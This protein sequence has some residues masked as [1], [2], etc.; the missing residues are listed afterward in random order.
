MITRI[1]RLQLAVRSHERS[2]ELFSRLFDAAVVR[3]D[4]LPKLGARRRVLR[5]GESEL[6]LLEPDGLGIVAQ[7]ISRYPTPIFAVGLATNDV[8]AARASLD[9][10]AI[11]HEVLGD[12]LW[13]TGEWLG[14]PGMRVV[15][16]QDERRES[17]GLLSRVY[18]T[19]H[20][21]DD[22]SRAAD[23]LAKVFDLDTANYVPIESAT[24]GYR[25]TLT[26]FQSE[27]LDRI[28]TV[29]PRDRSKA[30][31]RFY[32]RRGPCLYMCFAE[33]ANMRALRVR[34]DAEIPELWVGDRT[35]NA[36]DTLFIPPQALDGLLLG[37]SRESVAWDW[38]G[39]PEKVRSA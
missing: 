34:L 14:I 35:G 15:L 26:R 19:T 30:M 37:V 2:T 5:L 17:A 10:R 39:A 33:C 32:V 36:P 8:A 6:E 3:E 12:Q 7:H 31:G 24:Y 11:H 4:R 27:R 18:E 1:D 23:R 21:M 38:S 29:T 25:G 16:S 20:L 28:E 13:L 9:G 22:F